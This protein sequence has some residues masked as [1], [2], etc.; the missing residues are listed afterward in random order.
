MIGNEITWIMFMILY[1]LP[2]IIAAKRKHNSK[3]A[4]GVMTVLLGWTGIMWI[5]ALIWAFTGN[6]QLNKQGGV[7]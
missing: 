5:Y 4:I 6:V 3:S 1:F 7:S 2:W